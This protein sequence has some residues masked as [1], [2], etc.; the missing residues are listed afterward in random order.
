MGT[1][2]MWKCLPMIFGM[3]LLFVCGDVS[4]VFRTSLTEKAFIYKWMGIRWDTPSQQLDDMICLRMRIAVWKWFWRLSK[5]TLEDF[6]VTS[7]LFASIYGGCRL[8]YVS[9]YVYTI[10]IFPYTHISLHLYIYIYIY[11][12]YYIHIYIYK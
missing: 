12:W 9:I 7:C 11:K 8:V 1:I 4:E 6:L 2:L 10:H 5:N 3:F